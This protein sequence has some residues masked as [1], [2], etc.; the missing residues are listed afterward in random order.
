[1]LDDQQPGDEVAGENE[2]QIHTDESTRQKTFVVVEDNDRHDGDG[3]QAV[4]LGNVGQRR[5]FARRRVRLPA[6]ADH[7]DERDK[8]AMSFTGSTNGSAT[9]H[10]GAHMTTRAGRGRPAR[11]RTLMGHSHQGPQRVQARIQETIGCVAPHRSTYSAM[12]GSRRRRSQL[13][14][15][16]RAPPQLQLLDWVVRLCLELPRRRSGILLLRQPIKSTGKR[17][18]VP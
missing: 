14:P 17:V 3:P 15:S 7:V 18:A 10:T 9:R 8:V 12:N 16:H 13:L 5:E 4:Q 2:E 1:M 11:R 6:K